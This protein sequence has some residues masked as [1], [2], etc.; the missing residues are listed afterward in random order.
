MHISD[1][2]LAM[3]GQAAQSDGRFLT[4][5]GEMFGQPISFAIQAIMGG[6]G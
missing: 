6:L 2:L 5:A 1:I 4:K 3:A